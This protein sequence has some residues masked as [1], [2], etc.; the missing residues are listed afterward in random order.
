MRQLLVSLLAIAIS[1][2]AYAAN[3]KVEFATNMGSIVIEVYPEKAPETVGN[4]LG[5]V[6]SGFYDGTIFHR[7]I[8]G[9]MIQGGGYTQTYERKKTGNPIRNEADN[10]LNNRTGTVAMARTGDPHSATA[11]FF[12]NV[13]DNG[14]LDYRSPTARGYGY[15]VFGKVVDGMDV[16]KRIAAAQ[17]GR[18]GPFAKDAPIEMVIIERAKEL[19]DQK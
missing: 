15:A 12:I 19:G 10:G 18:G 1:T 16:I 14:F 3:P 4:F 11:Q 17:T 2:G 5:Y 8:A 13:A 6:R 9:F 7:V